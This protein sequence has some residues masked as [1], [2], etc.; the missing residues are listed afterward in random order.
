MKVITIYT[1]QDWIY[2]N[3]SYIYFKKNT[4]NHHSARWDSYQMNGGITVNSGFQED[5]VPYHIH[6]HFIDR[7]D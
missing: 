7:K 1:A 3:H 2:N 5:D 6:T 4:Q